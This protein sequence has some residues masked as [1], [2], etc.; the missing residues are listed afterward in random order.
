MKTCNAEWTS[1][2]PTTAVDMTESVAPLSPVTMMRYLGGNGLPLGGTARFVIPLLLLRPEMGSLESHPL[3]HIINRLSEHL[4]GQSQADCSFLRTRTAD[5]A[6]KVLVRKH[7][8]FLQ[9]VMDFQ[10]VDFSAQ[11]ESPLGQCTYFPTC[12]YDPYCY[13][14]CYPRSIQRPHRRV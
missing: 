1:T 10:L 9:S 11:H 3:V 7:G 5:V 8:R 2:N 4:V 13:S 12:Y 14:Y 6:F